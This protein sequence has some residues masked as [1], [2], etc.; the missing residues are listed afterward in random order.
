MNELIKKL[1]GLRCFSASHIYGTMFMLKI[2]Y[3]EVH[4]SSDESIST[5]DGEWGITIEEARWSIRVNDKTTTSDENQTE[6]KAA[7]SD[8]TN[9]VIE[10]THFD[11]QTSQLVISFSN[12]FSLNVESVFQEQEPVFS[13]RC[14][15]SLKT[16][17][18]IISFY[19]DGKTEEER[20]PTKLNK[21][22][23]SQ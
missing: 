8:L 1:Q 14:L 15:W 2:G 12:N 13:P 22:T 11:S 16:P 21:L 23:I 18:S 3:P 9:Q 6:Q 7:I 4:L 5:V 17:N 20:E 10:T 19:P